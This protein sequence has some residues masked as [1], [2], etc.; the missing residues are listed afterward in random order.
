ML[1]SSAEEGW[2][3]GA[4]GA[5]GT[6]SLCERPPPSKV[7]ARKG[8]AFH[9]WQDTE[10]PSLNCL[11]LNPHEVGRATTLTLPPPSP[12]FPLTPSLHQPVLFS[13]SLSTRRAGCCRPTGL[14]VWK[15][16]QKSLRLE[17]GEHGECKEQGEAESVDLLAFLTT[18]GFFEV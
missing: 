14:T 9:C 5:P 12:P 16:L 18:C 7:W 17:C 2:A 13:F 15:V 4:A 8:A 6:V 11:F 3:C 10:D 1:A